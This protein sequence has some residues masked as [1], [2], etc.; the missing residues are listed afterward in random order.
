MPGGVS[1]PVRMFPP[2]P[3]FMARGEGPWIVDVEGQ[4]YLDYCLAFGPLL[5]GHAHPEVVGAVQARVA[6][7]ALFGAPGEL[8]VALAQRVTRHVPS[9]AMLRFTST[10]TE[11][12]MHAVRLARAATGRDAVVKVDGG[13]HGSSDSML[14]KAGSG[15]ETFGVPTS[16]GVP[17]DAAKHTVVVP[18]NSLPAM[19]Q[20]LRA[21]PCAAV[22]VEPVLANIGPIPPEKGYLQGLRKLCS[23]HGALLLFDEVVTGFRLGLGGA[24]ARYGVVPDLTLL[25]KVLGGG[26][27]LAAFGGRRELMERLAPLGDTYQAGTFSGNPLSMAAGLATLDALAQQPYDA[28]DARAASLRKALGDLARDQKVGVVQGEG[29]LFQLF[30]TGDDAPVRDATQARR[31]HGAAYMALFRG[32][33]ERDVYLPPAQWET[34]FLSFAHT[35]EHLEAT[36]EAFQ[37]CLG[38]G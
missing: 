1:S 13:F 15:A 24:Q 35:P 26:L 5:L 17:R 33:L 19:E 12:A 30:F 7:G 20:A 14:V 8:E 25:G 11:A 9:M 10:G 32:L 21:Q 2:H 29:S 6:Q 36:V 38:S 28:L 4:R 27:P 31:A 3:V 34:C 23:E 37:A 18:F 22:I 16:A